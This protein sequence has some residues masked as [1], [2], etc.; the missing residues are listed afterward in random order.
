MKKISL[1]LI[2][3]LGI[4]TYLQKTDTGSNPFLINNEQNDRIALNISKA[5]QNRL[6]NVQ[7]KGQ[8]IIQRVLRDDNQGRRHQKFILHLPSGQSLL[9]AH[10]IDL[11][12]RIKDLKKGDS[13]EFYGEYEWNSKGGIV[14]WTHRDP[15]GRHINGWLK[16]NN[17]SYQ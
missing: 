1:I 4:A 9:I 11:A 15:G 5:Y 12:P 7:V 3:I 17:R 13:I 8:G 16:H 14:H 2:I 6:S 10:N